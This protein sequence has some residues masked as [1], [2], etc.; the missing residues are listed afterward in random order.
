MARVK[1]INKELNQDLI[2]GNFIND[3]SRTIFSLGDFV[4]ESNF[5]GRKSRN[6]NNTLSSFPNVITLDTLGITDE[7]SKKIF[8]ISNNFD[9]NFDKSD[10]KSYVKF[11]S[12]EDLFRV[13]YE[14]IIKKYP[15]SLFINTQKSV[16]GNN[17]VFDFDYDEINNISTFRIPSSII[18]NPYSLIFNDGNNATLNNDNLKNINLSFLNYVIW[19]KD[20][21]ENDYK[22]IGFTGDTP[23]NTSVRLKVM[24][25]PFPEI[26]FLENTYKVNYHIKPKI[27]EFNK[28]INDLS[29]LEAYFLSNR[30]LDYS[31]FNIKLKNINVNES[32]SISYGDSEILWTTVD[33]YNP[34][35]DG[36]LFDRFSN[37]IKTI[38][39]SYDNIK[40]DLIT[41]FLTPSSLKL[42]DLTDE[43]KMSKLLRI[44][45]REFDEIRIFI[46]AIVNINKTS[47]SKKDNIPDVLVKNLARTFGWDVFN[48][49]TEKDITETFFSTEKETNLD[50]LLPAEVDIELWR[51]ILIN[52]NYYWKSKGTRHAIKSMFRLI[53]IPEPFINITEYIYTVEG[54]INPNEVTLSL[55]DIPS[56]S[57]PFDKEGYPIAPV[58]TN[59]FYYQIAGDNDNGQTYINLYRDLGFKINRVIDNKKSWTRD[60]F[61]ERTHYTTPNYYQEDS[62]LLINTKEVDITLDTSRGI[63]YDVFTYN[64]NVDNPFTSTEITK[65]Y[66]FINVELNV[67]DPTTFQL[68]EVPLSGSIIQLNYNGVTLTPLVNGETDY[69]YTYS[70]TTNSASVTI[71]PAKMV[72]AT[73]GQDIITVSYIYDRLGTSGYTQ[74]EYYVQAPTVL[75]AG[76]ILQLNGEPK[77]DVQ[78]TV[79]GITLSKG[80]TLYTGD[81]IIN[82]SDKTQLL[83]QNSELKNFLNTNPIIRIWAIM[84][85]Y[86]PSNAEKKSEVHRVDSLTRSKFYYNSAINKNVFVLN[87]EA[88]DVDSIKITHNGIT[89]TNGKDFTL[90]PTNKK[91]ILLPPKISI[92]SVLNAYYIIDGGLKY[93]DN[94]ISFSE[95]NIIN[96]PNADVSIFK[97]GTS[98]NIS[99][100]LNNDNFY[101]IQSASTNQLILNGTITDESAGQ[102]VKITKTSTEQLLPSDPTF[103]NIGD[104]SFLEYL[105]LIT[106]RLINVK[107][108]KTITD[109]NGGF[110]P[111]ILNL[112]DKYIKRGDLPDNDPL[113]SNGYTNSNLYDFI[114]QYNGYFSKFIMELLPATIILNKGGILLRNTQFSRQKYRYP[115]GVNLNPDL[116]WLGNDGSEFKIK[117]PDID[118]NSPIT[119]SSLSFSNATPNDRIVKSNTLLEYDIRINTTTFK[120]IPYRVRIISNSESAGVYGAIGRVTSNGILSNNNF[121]Q[122][123]TIEIGNIESVSCNLFNN[124]YSFTNIKLILEVDTKNNGLYVEQDSLFFTVA[125]K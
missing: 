82:P 65:P 107:N 13:S 36:V 72:T 23:T 48:L 111:T 6:Y 10:I 50:N 105:E 90:N 87:Y 81:F 53:G 59:D 86:T 57:F 68:P 28:F 113:H 96:V 32:G 47:Y 12:A 117:I 74:V 58:E 4:V 34:T 33:G 118:S 56:G 112:Y 14:N 80:T 29:K 11:G 17:T 88:F 31:G 94:N 60:G 63:E 62:R 99:G 18:D 106:R 54:K 9:I 104:M 35:I 1:R 46:D 125:P 92:G 67:D 71:N 51:R 97:K 124:T 64:K 49:V 122:D 24:G 26:G 52:T 3:A 27:L 73:N 116:G 110:Y 45:G 70:I 16:G 84:D 121:I 15:A 103:P 37:T 8:N 102:I 89:L 19:R 42:Y 61:K 95:P 76:T 115:R 98:I 93:K 77:G 2:G 41:R 79:N 85:G 5:T 38:G 119:I 40:T 66:I 83:I 7:E 22:I 39:K 100:S 114:S 21:P 30:K 120:V 69:D 101:I 44:Y 43:G 55:E 123:E 78:L 20:D 75:A 108:R 25:N 109:N 91:E